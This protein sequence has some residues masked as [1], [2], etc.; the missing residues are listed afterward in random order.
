MIYN[1]YIIK[2]NRDI[3]ILDYNMED[4]TK[5]LEDKLLNWDV[6]SKNIIYKKNNEMK[7]RIIIFYDSFLLNIISLYLEIF[8]EIYMIKNIYDDKFIDIIKPD[9]IFEFRVERF[10]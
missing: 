9:Y 4:K 6:L 3:R 1:N 5:E 10:L 7:K 2:D 8:Y